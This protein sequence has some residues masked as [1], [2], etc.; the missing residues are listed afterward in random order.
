MTEKEKDKLVKEN[1]W[2]VRDVISKYTHLMERD[3][4]E[5][6]GLLGLAEGIEKYKEGK[7]TK[8][9]TYVRHWIKARVIAAV[10]EN[11]TVHIPWNKINQ[12]IKLQK[13]E[14]LANAGISGN[15][16]A[17]GVSLPRHFPNNSY[18]PKFELSLDSFSTTNQTG[19]NSNSDSTSSDHIELQSS[20]SSEDLYIMEERETQNH[21]F[22]ALNES[23]LSN[24]EKKAISLRFGLDRKENPMTFGEV[25][26]LTG[27]SI[28]GAQKAVVRG[29]KKLK[30]NTHMKHLLE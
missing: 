14:E 4:L 5:A 1:R 13:E 10:Y 9:S 29:L 8:V 27:L 19:H 6:A 24:L 21:V 15:G 25:A 12:H 26:A 20:L 3:E 2:V 18:T 23:D 11:R 28:M 7:G 16:T 17:F 22:F 30:S